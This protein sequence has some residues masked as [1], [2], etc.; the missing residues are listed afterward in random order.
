MQ[1]K[2]RTLLVSTLCFL[3]G[4]SPHFAF[5]QTMN[6]NKTILELLPRGIDMVDE[7]EARNYEQIIKMGESAYPALCHE[8]LATKDD[9]IVG[10]ILSI[11]IESKGDK[12][13]PLTAIRKLASIRTGPSKQDTDM[14]VIVVQA[15]GKMGKPEDAKYLHQQLNDPSDAV[16]INSIRSLGHIG[17][18]ESVS[19]IAAWVAKNKNRLPSAN[20]EA[21][22]AIDFISQRS[23]TQ[24]SQK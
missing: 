6:D 11:F 24:S 3:T 7:A 23:K 16:Q 13:L 5:S 2:Y 1:N 14:R 9:I 18:K 22:K 21:G 15:L 17:G 19:L 12:T 4:A 10:R 20:A 8:L